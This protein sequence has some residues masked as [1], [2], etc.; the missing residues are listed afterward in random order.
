ML[1]SNDTI[2]TY[3]YEV[4]HVIKEQVIAAVKTSSQ[5]IFQL[6]NAQLIHVYT[7]QG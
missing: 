7:L 1:L 6:D 4:Q 5:F 2:H 3:I